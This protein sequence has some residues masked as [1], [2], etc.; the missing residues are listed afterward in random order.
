MK[1]KIGRLI[2]VRSLAEEI[3]VNLILSA[4]PMCAKVTVVYVRAC[5]YKYLNFIENF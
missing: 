4:G 2:D 1:S 5:L 3:P